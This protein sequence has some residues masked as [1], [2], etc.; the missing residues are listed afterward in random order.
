[1]ILMKREK[2]SG[3]VERTDFWLCGSEQIGHSIIGPAG[4]V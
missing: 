3:T 4:F 2:V 1:M